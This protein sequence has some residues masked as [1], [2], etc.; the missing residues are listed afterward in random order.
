MKG[1]RNNDK[2]GIHRKRND[3][4][5]ISGHPVRWDG[6]GCEGD[7]MLNRRDVALMIAT[8]ILI[9]VATECLIWA[10]TGEYAILR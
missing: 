1:G 10:I 3:V 5:G 9:V 7:G 2:K 4:V 8:G 6:L